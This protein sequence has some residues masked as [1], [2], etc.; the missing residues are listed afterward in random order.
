MLR[1]QRASS[2]EE[3]DRRYDNYEQLR[4]ELDDA[5][6]LDEIERAHQK[7]NDR[8]TLYLTELGLPRWKEMKTKKEQRFIEDDDEIPDLCSDDEDSDDEDSDT[9]QELHWRVTHNK[10]ARATASTNSNATSQSQATSSQANSES[11]KRAR[12]KSMNYQPDDK[13]LRQPALHSANTLH[14]EATQK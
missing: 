5:R 11:S 14:T 9:T 7:Y 2:F 4:I 10:A 6:T 8:E 12:E 1:Y 3:L 13:L